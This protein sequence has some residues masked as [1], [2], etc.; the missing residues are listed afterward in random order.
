MQ[1]AFAVGWTLISSLNPEDAFATIKT[2]C[3]GV[4]LTDHVVQ[5]LIKSSNETKQFLPEGWQALNLGMQKNA[6]E[7]QPGGNKPIEEM[8]KGLPMLLQ[9]E[10][11][12]AT[13][14]S[15]DGEKK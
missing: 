14:N 13:G 7:E 1:I 8:D 5:E 10:V 9:K 11:L 12:D 3:P 6:V 15:P 2:L 4:D